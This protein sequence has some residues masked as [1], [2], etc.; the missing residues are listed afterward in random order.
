MFNRARRSEAARQCAGVWLLVQVVS[1]LR[2][3]P[4][5]PHGAATGFGLLEAAAGCGDQLRRGDLL[6]DRAGRV[7]GGDLFV[8]RFG[9]DRGRGG[10]EDLALLPPSRPDVAALDAAGGVDAF[11]W[12]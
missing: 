7:G 5:A 8:G 12:R 9:G 11:R 4:S 6:G 1:A 3:G 10:G 2:Q